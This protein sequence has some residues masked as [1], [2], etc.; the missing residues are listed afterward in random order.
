MRKSG[1]LVGVLSGSL[2]LL[3]Q[4][5]T[6]TNPAAKPSAGV[7][8]TRPAPPPAKGSIQ[9]TKSYPFQQALAALNGKQTAGP[10]VPSVSAVRQATMTEGSAMR[11]T[12]HA[13]E[14][15]S[16]KLPA[17]QP[18]PAVVA[19]LS[20]SAQ[21]AL[22][23]A[24]KAKQQD[25][26]PSAGKDGRVTYTFGEG[27]PTVV[28]SPLHVSIIELQPG[29]TVTGEPAIGDS[30]R[31]ELLPGTSGK[32]E[33]AQPLVMVKPHAANLD[34]NLVIT[35]DK[36]T[37]YL[38][39]V[40]RETE[41]MARTAFSYSEDESAR[42]RVFVE[43]QRQ[44]RDEREA[45]QTVTAVAGD[46]IDK[47][48]FSYDIKGGN[49]VIRPVRVMDDGQKTYI[50][51]PDAVLHQD[52]PALVVLNPRLKKEK[53]EEIVNYRVKGNLYIVDRLFDRAALVIGNGKTAEKVTIS[54][55]TP[56]AEK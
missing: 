25:S 21:Q 36:R 20:P 35:T 38:R 26:V 54:R 19:A 31:W 29:E 37:Y 46:A 34:T 30:I 52:L 13:G 47:L 16:Y 43:E 50:T 1:I 45:A 6:Q 22:E 32:G 23:I 40:S 42:W 17:A 53:A 55:V 2:T 7:P 48:N 44:K 8:Q 12:P 4:S 33:S 9:D 5:A 49:A 27:L 15:V 56:L 18:G 11:R 39:L 10:S 51:M 3:G 41:Y 14:R 24:E 28:C